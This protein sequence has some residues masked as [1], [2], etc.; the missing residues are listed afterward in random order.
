MWECNVSSINEQRALFEN[1][2]RRPETIDPSLIR[3]YYPK[4]RDV[5]R[6]NDSKHISYVIICID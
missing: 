1:N 6:E 3:A 2:I 5:H 4:T